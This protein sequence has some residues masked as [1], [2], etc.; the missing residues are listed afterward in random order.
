[1]PVGRP[2]KNPIEIDLT[3]ALEPLHAPVY[4]L[5]NKAECTWVEA[6]GSLIYNENRNVLAAIRYNANW[7]EAWDI[8]E[9][10]SD[11]SP[12]A[13]QNVPQ[14]SPILT[15]PRTTYDAALDEVA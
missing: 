3:S 8:R 4:G 10:S 9:I 7:E 1:M 6:N 5:W 13:R 14:I 2:R 15:D 12:V 11:G